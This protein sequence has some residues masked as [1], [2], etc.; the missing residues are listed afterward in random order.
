MIIFS[1]VGIAIIA[2]I[3]PALMGLRMIEGDQHFG[4]MGLGA[5]SASAADTFSAAIVDAIVEPDLIISNKATRKVLEIDVEDVLVWD[6]RRAEVL[7]T[8]LP[9]FVGGEDKL[10][11]DR[12]GVTKDNTVNGSDAPT[13]DSVA[14]GTRPAGS[15]LHDDLGLFGDLSGKT[16]VHPTVPE[17]RTS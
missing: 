16:S 10:Q 14:Q 13:A 8:N 11:S 5:V 4:W 6:C 2:M 7:S 9:D 12:C 15:A 3:I 17:K 1:L